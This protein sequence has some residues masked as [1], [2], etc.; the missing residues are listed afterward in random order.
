MV[1]FCKTKS[2]TA[3]RENIGSLAVKERICLLVVDQCWLQYNF[4]WWDRL[5]FK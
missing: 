4:V 1:F 2:D 5:K 3:Y